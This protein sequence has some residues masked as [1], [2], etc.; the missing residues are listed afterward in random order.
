MWVQ[1]WHPQHAL[2]AALRAHDYAAFAAS[3]LREREMAGLPPY[4]HLALLRAEARTLDVA[5]AFLQAAGDA[6]GGPEGVAIYPPVPMSLQRVANVER[7]QM[8][9]ESRSRPALQRF[10]AAW[11]PQLHTLRAAHRGLIRWAVD[12][13]PLTI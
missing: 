1:T 7:A 10:L 12:V 2:Y 5:R 4:A 6:A 3:Q 13:D 9:V 8:L 11:A